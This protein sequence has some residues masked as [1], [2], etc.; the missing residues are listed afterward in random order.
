M[1]TS[2]K[3]L[4]PL[5]ETGIF[6]PS[7]LNDLGRLDIPDIHPSIDTKKVNE[8]D[9]VIRAVS[10]DTGFAIFP[11]IVDGGQLSNRPDLIALAIEKRRNRYLTLHGQQIVTRQILPDTVKNELE[12]RGDQPKRALV[13][14]QSFTHDAAPIDK[15]IRLFSAWVRVAN[16]DYRSFYTDYLASLG[17]PNQSQLVAFNR[18]FRQ[19]RE[20]PFDDSNSVEPHLY[21]H[22]L[23]ALYM[24]LANMAVA[25]WATQHEIPILYR[26]IGRT[27]AELI[28]AKMPESAPD[29][30][31]YTLD[32][33]P[34]H[35]IEHAGRPALYTHITSPL[36]R[37][38]DLINHLQISTYLAGEDPPFTAKSLRKVQEK[39]NQ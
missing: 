38:A 18:A 36:R 4:P 13:I 5:A 2:P 20:L 3:Q 17:N 10:T 19:A 8:I 34:H 25:E 24:A 11:A 27:A 15:S 23:V 7:G 28:G 21:S 9:D 39:I 35:G 1:P 33:L 12:F 16:Y 22:Q 26:I 29:K 30:A 37:A 14:S 32:A 31:Y 6:T